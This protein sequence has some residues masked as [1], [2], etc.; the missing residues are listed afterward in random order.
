[1]FHRHELGEILGVESPGV[2]YLRPVSVDDLDRL[3]PGQS[4]CLSPPRRDLVQLPFVRHRRPP[5]AT[6]PLLPA[7][8]D[9]S[10][11]QQT[12]W[13]KLGQV[14]ATE[15]ARCARRMWPELTYSRQIARSGRGIMPC[16]S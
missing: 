10:S 11:P 2:D 7:R 13:T 16:S 9:H 14:P 5:W 4:Y 1:M 15:L 12:M 3:A 8:C 6:A